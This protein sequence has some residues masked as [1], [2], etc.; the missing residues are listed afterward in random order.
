MGIIGRTECKISYICFK[1]NFKFFIL[2]DRNAK[3]KI[4]IF[5]MYTTNTYW[6]LVSII[7]HIKYKYV[8]K[9]NFIIMNVKLQRYCKRI[10][11][12]MRYLIWYNTAAAGCI[13]YISAHRE[14]TFLKCSTGIWTKVASSSSIIVIILHT[15]FLLIQLY[16]KYLQ[17]MSY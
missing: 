14:P 2:F 17:R 9:I 15:I 4:K 12:K 7:H 5:V 6:G 1:Y 13:F 8:F 10:S 16:I 3:F 11:E